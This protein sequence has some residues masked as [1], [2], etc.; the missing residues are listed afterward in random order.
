M[1]TNRLLWFLSLGHWVEHWY[2][3]AFWI[4]LPIFAADFGL[5][6]LQI[7][8]LASARAFLSAIMHVIMGALS[9]IIGRPLLLL[10]GCLTWLALGFF[11]MSLVPS[12]PALVLLCGAM[13]AAVGLWHPP[14]MAVIS[15]VFPERRGF[16]LSAHELA[17]NLANVLTPTLVGLALVTVSWRLVMGAHLLPGLMV[18]LLFWLGMPR[19]ARGGGGR[20]QLSDYGAMARSVLANSTVLGMSAVSALRSASQTSLSAFLPIY[21]AVT[22][23][24]TV[25]HLGLYLSALLALGVV[26]PLIGGTVSDRFGRRP[27]LLIGLFGAGLLSLL[28]PSASPGPVLLGLLAAVG[29]F[30]YALRSVIFAHALD[31]SA[32]A[33]AASTVGFIFGVQGVVSGLAPAALGLLADSVGLASTL[34]A[35]GWL[36][37]AAGLLVLMLPRAKSQVSRPRPQ[38]A[39]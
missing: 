13:G 12:F 32:S 27:V 3:A 19:L 29:L 35:A 8:M 38:V 15:R 39:T 36:T 10:T 23:G 5:S 21:L 31:A 25:D 4:F 7:G 20:V 30:L 34:Q 33:G 28:L 2:E 9:D 24:M 1:K 6:Y 18:A 37:L 22:Y 14:A 11:V 16:A 17:G 26:S